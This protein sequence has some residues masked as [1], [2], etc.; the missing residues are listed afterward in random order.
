MA[1]RWHHR[2]VEMAYFRK[3]LGKWKADINKRKISTYLSSLHSI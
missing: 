3:R 1:S 2:K